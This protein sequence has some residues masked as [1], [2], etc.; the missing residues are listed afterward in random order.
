MCFGLPLNNSLRNQTCSAV[1]TQSSRGRCS[2][3]N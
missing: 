1:R 2:F 3:Q